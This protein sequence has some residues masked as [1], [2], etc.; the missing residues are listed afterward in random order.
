MSRKQKRR[1][2][3]KR[4]GLVMEK[5]VRGP[6]LNPSMQMTIWSMGD[7]I[8]VSVGGHVTQMPARWTWHHVLVLASDIRHWGLGSGEEICDTDKRL[9]MQMME[10]RSADSPW[11]RIR[12]VDEQERRVIESKWKRKKK[13]SRFWRKVV[14]LCCPC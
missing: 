11:M 6:Y 13:P 3:K 10:Q 5:R 7:F 1:N 12:F 9:M 4:T 2:R 14:S 8:R